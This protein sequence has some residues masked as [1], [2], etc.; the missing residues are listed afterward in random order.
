ME[1]FVTIA[2][3]EK[4]SILDI[5]RDRGYTSNILPSKKPPDGG[6][7]FF[8]NPSEQKNKVNKINFV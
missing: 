5:G 7:T 3:F 4:G 1:L 2:T 6:T 8:G